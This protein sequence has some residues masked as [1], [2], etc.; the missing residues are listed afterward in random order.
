MSASKSAP[1]R[2]SISFLLGLC[3]LAAIALLLFWDVAPARFPPNAH[4]ALSAFPLALIALAA[5]AHRLERP[6]TRGELG[7]TAI[8]AAAFLCWAA[9]QFWPNQPRA[10]LLNDLAVALFV[11]DVWWTIAGR[12]REAA[13]ALA[14]KSRTWG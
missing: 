10:T 4:D 11:L 12:Q 6:W 9:N 1:A 8:L 7:R 3:T 5:V 2:G 13:S 14:M